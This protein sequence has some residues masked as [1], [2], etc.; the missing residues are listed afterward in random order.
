MHRLLL[1]VLSLSSCVLVLP[2]LLANPTDESVKDAMR[3]ATKFYVENVAHEGG[4]QGTYTADLSYAYAGKGSE[5]ITKFSVTG[6]TT[7]AV[8]YAYLKAWEVTGDRLFLD[9]ARNA[10][11]GLIKGQ[12]CS[13][14]WDYTTELDPQVRATDYHYRADGECPA[15]PLEGR[16]NMTNLDNNSTQSALR[17]MMR[18]D[19]AL[20][21]EDGPIHDATLY[22]LDGIVQ[23]QY[24]N[25]AWAQRFDRA[26]DPAQYPVRP[27]TI[28]DSWSRDWPGREYYGHYTFNDDVIL[29]NID[30]LFEAS[31]TYKRPQY[32]AAA[33]KA[34]D[35]MILAQFPEP[36]PG[37]AQQYNVNM[38]PAWGRIFEPPGI[39]G[40]ES[41]S[42]IRGL[43]FLY[44]ETGKKKYLEPIPRAL[45]Y[46]RRSA[47]EHK[48]KQMIARFFEVKTNKPLFV[49]K[50][51]LVGTGVNFGV[52]TDGYEVTY[53]PSTPAAHYG[54][55]GRLESVEQMQEEYNR[56]VAADPASLRRSYPID[57]TGVWFGERPQ[58]TRAELAPRVAEA[59]ATLDER[60]AWTSTGRMEGPGRLVRVR[61]AQDLVAVIDGDKII[62]IPGG[63]TLEV[64]EGT[65]PPGGRLIRIGSLVG[66]LQLFCEY[67]AAN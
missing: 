60:G 66:N 48:G 49:T 27:A 8:G 20:Q 53:D 67:L 34:G 62:P 42:V 13:G 63:S 46:L 36:Q 56:V 33:E 52:P 23:A 58:P 24:P 55:F 6:G 44:R 11:Q 59:I 19:Q 45:A 37:W 43:L 5:G 65:Q 40:R 32:R 3:R 39:T 14:G 30:V 41:L 16:K 50:G 47:F 28:P 26:P 21:F 17:F 38:H 4:Y 22:A 35:F 15:V 61:A 1:C 64:F 9:A 7:P 54:Y 10:A 51:T 25:G 29:N 57:T 12:M 2:P 18:L 31:E